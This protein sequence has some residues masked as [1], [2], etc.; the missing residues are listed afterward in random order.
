M[1]RAT[2]SSYEIEQM[3][4]AGKKIVEAELAIIKK[5]DGSDAIKKH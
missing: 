5:N 4:A 2:M 3:T 1:I